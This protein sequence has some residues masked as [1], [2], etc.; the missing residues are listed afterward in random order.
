MIFFAFLASLATLWEPLG[1][2][3]WQFSRSFSEFLQIF[4]KKNSPKLLS[5]QKNRVFFDAPCSWTLKINE[6][7]WKAI[8]FSMILLI[9]TDSHFQLV[10][11][12]SGQFLNDF[13]WICPLKWLWRH[14]FASP[15]PLLGQSG[16]SFQFP[17]GNLETPQ[18][19]IF[20]AFPCLGNIFCDLGP[21]RHLPRQFFQ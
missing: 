3:V 12:N 11:T 16:D 19:S 7:R 1:L 5:I 20:D 6:N 21:P 4:H 17:W 2:P 9:F 13:E 8:V 10:G 18:S 14:W 15:W